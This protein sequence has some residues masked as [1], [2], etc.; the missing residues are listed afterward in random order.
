MSESTASGHTDT[1]FS[2]PTR[3]V[4]PVSLSLRKDS[5]RPKS[6]VNLHHCKE[7]LLA[8]A[9]EIHELEEVNP[10]F[11]YAEDTSS[12]AAAPTREAIRPRG[13]RV[14]EVSEV[15]SRVARRA[16]FDYVSVVDG[17]LSSMD[18]EDDDVDADQGTQLSEVLIRAEEVERDCETAE[19]HADDQVQNRM[20]C[21]H[22]FTQWRDSL[23]PRQTS[24]RMRDARVLATKYRVFSALKSHRATSRLSLRRKQRGLRQLKAVALAA[25]KQQEQPPSSG[26]AK[27]NESRWVPRVTWE[28]ALTVLL[29]ALVH[30]AM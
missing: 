14:L 11:D 1:S 7:F 19:S 18:T 27:A 25:R 12:D 26:E 9:N 2:V 28:L 17:S 13:G 8:C 30:S 23:R 22:A 10:S 21:R 4:A 29:G 20:I 24:E 3:R 15:K 5:G 6:H 16:M